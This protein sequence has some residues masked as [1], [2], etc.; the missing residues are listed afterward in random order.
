MGMRGV[1]QQ[2]LYLYDGSIKESY[3]SDLINKLLTGRAQFK[4]HSLAIQPTSYK[5]LIERL[6]IATRAHL[7]YRVTGLHLLPRQYLIKDPMACFSSEYLHRTTKMATVIIIRHPAACIRSLR[8]L[9]W[10]F[11]LA[12][13]TSQ[14]AL[15]S[16]HLQPILGRINPSNVS[17]LEESALLWT[18]IYSTLIKY[19]DRNPNIIVVR[20]EDLSSSPIEVLMDLYNRLGL[21]FTPWT[22]RRISEY[23]QSGN[24]ID[25]PVGTAHELYRHSRAISSSWHGTFS[26]VELAHIKELTGQVSDRFYSSTDW[27]LEIQA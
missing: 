24:I 25:A 16:R 3:Y 18:S 2:F 5:E 13:L 19:A 11:N 8:R 17:E 4:S 23:T 6:K 7:K 27:E 26:A 14:P 21:P 10:R 22:E 12:H 15:M 1:N 9:G 20:H